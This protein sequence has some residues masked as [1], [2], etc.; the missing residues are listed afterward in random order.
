VRVWPL[1]FDEL[2]AD[3]FD[4]ELDDEFDELQAASTDAAAST[5]TH[6]TTLRAP[7]DFI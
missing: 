5:A 1:N 4:G 3:D 7:S 2:A 6:T